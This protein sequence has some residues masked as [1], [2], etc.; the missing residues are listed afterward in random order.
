M[1]SRS[2]QLSIKAEQLV[3]RSTLLI[4]SS[5]ALLERCHG[6]RTALTVLRIDP[7]KRTVEKG[8]ATGAP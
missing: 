6:I 8:K 4:R 1:S 5:N 3:E 2:I 7:I